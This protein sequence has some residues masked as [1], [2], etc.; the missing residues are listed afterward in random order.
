MTDNEATNIL[1]DGQTTSYVQLVDKLKRVLLFKEM[2]LHV[3]KTLF[4]KPCMAAIIHKTT[5]FYIIVHWQ[6]S[7]DLAVYSSARMWK[8]SQP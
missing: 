7:R 1:I 4:H 6:V 3:K 8:E 5:E 2:K